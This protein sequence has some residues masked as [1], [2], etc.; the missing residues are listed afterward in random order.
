MSA[1]MASASR[2]LENLAMPLVA[3]LVPASQGDVVRLALDSDGAWFYCR[4]EGRLAGGDLLCSVQEAQWWPSLM[5]DG[6][7]PGV[8]YAVA[9]DRVLSVVRRHAPT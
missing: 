6:I 8:S 4:V 2:K 1:R 9:P 7:V 3:G 5:I